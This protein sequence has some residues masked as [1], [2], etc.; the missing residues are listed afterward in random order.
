VNTLGNSFC[1]LPFVHQH[2]TM[3]GETKVCCDSYHFEDFI[4]EHTQD[5][6]AEFNNPIMQDIRNKM[7]AGEFPRHCRDCYQQEAISTESPRTRS[8][9][10]WF[11]NKPEL[12]N[13]NIELHRNNKPLTPVGLDIR[14]SSRCALKCRT[15]NPFSSS[16]IMN[17]VNK[18]EDIPNSLS[19]MF[20]YRK[21]QGYTNNTA[22]MVPVDKNLS[23]LNLVGGE[24][25][26]EDKNIE[27]LEKILNL[28]IDPEIIINTSMARKNNK[29]VNILKNFTNVC[30]V[31]SIDA[32]GKLNDYIRHG[33]NFETVC[34]NV[35]NIPR[36]QL[37]AFNT[38]VSMYNIFNLPSMIEFI[39][40]TWRGKL[41]FLNYTSNH[42][43]TELKNIPLDMRPDIKELWAKVS[44]VN[45]VTLDN[46]KGLSSMLNEDNYTTQ[47]FQQFKEY[48][49]Y[50]DKL[51]GEDI[52][53]AEPAW[54]EYFNK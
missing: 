12:V 13:T 23:R 30:Y 9:Q 4:S 42:E 51:R 15:C 26:I 10:W 53:I 14:F 37:G 5:M 43:P 34:E 48:T 49:I 38:T 19:T 17:E 50:T 32:T 33:S 36:N 1:A 2:L 39:N 31:V 52:A 46:L 45:T 24:P 8:N 6:L 27:L 29:L 7:L 21:T 47:G 44:D 35:D 40:K 18:L 3:T 20:F 41:H 16:T 28:N 11:N 25:L 54:A 22:E